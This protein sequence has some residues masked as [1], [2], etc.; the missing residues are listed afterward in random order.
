MSNLEKIVIV[1]YLL[2]ILICVFIGVYYKVTS[3]KEFWPLILLLTITLIV[4]S[5]GYYNLFTAHKIAG[6]LFPIFL[7]AQYCLMGIYFKYIIKSRQTQKWII[8]SIPIMLGWNVYNSIFLQNLKMLNT[9]AILLACILYCVWSIAYFIELLNSETDEHLAQN[10]HFWICTGTLFF[11]SS[12]FFIIA[13]ILI[14]D[15]GDRELA[16]KLWFLVRLFNIILY[17]LYAYG[18]ICQ[19][20]HQ[21]SSILR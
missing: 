14:I 18:L 6:W 3:K 10:P 20:K 15:T 16:S 9:Y 17:G 11:Y 4:E 7:P 5:L 1:I 13:F 21:N 2:I 8:I 12:S 19:I